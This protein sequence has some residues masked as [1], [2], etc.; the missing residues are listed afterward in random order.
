M[1]RFLAFTAL[2]SFVLGQCPAPDETEKKIFFE[3]CHKGVKH[4]LEVKKVVLKNSEGQEVYPIDVK[5]ALNIEMQTVNSGSII[6]TIRADVDI[7]WWGKNW[8]S[9]CGW[10]DLPT[11]GLLHNLDECYSCPIKKGTSN[12]NIKVD[13][14][15]Y[16]QILGAIAGGVS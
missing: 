8:F 6:N 4:T 2:V 15:K 3:K 9:G 5:N 7:Q 1:F 12:M 11:F 10:H 13:M 16:S 14:S